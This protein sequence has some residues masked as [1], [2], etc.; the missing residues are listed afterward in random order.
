M[1]RDTAEVLG[2]VRKLQGLAAAERS[3][4]SIGSHAADLIGRLVAQ[5]GGLSEA[6]ADMRIR[7][8]LQR[9]EE[10]RRCLAWVRWGLGLQWYL[11][12]EGEE[13]IAKGIESGEWPPE[14]GR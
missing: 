12:E 5:R 7:C 10:R 11:I 9:E 1:Y 2:V 13:A 8:E 6:L 4:P 14:E 3:D